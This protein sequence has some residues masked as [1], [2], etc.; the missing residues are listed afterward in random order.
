MGSYNRWFQ[1]KVPLY[2]LCDGMTQET[3]DTFNI[4]RKS[5]NVTITFKLDKMV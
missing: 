5:K 4:K 1:Q 2:D 3:V